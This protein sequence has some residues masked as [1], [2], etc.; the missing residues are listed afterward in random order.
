MNGIIVINK[1]V[2]MTSN[3]VLSQLDKCFYQ[4]ACFRGVRIA[5]YHNVKAGDLIEAFI[6]VEEAQTLESVAQA[7]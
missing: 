5:N 6:K 2:G 1:S 4:I 3:R 7:Q